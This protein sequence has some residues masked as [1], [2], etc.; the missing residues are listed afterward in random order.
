MQDRGC[1]IKVGGLGSITGG[2]G[3]KGVKGDKGA[4]GA[5]GTRGARCKMQVAR[6]RLGAWELS[7]SGTGEGDKGGRGTKGGTAITMPTLHL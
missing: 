7:C 4:R 1:R 6:R 5:K 3:D 2:E